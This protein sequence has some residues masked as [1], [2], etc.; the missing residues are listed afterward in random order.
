MSKY[1]YEKKSVYQTEYTPDLG[2]KFAEKY[3]KFLKNGTTERRCVD[4]L[5]ALAEQNGFTA[6]EKGKQYKAGD[7]VYLI[8]RGKAVAFV[9][10]GRQPVEAGVHIA[11]AH[12]D[13]PRLDLKP[14]PVAEQEELVLLKTHYY[15][16]IKKYQ[17]TAIPLSLEG[18]IIKKDGTAVDVHDDALTFCISDLLPHLASAQCEKTLDKAIEGEDLRVLAGSIP[19]LEEQSDKVKSAILDLIHEK[20][21]IEEVDLQCA[22]LTMVPK[23][24]PAEVG[25]DKSLI[26]AYGQDDRICAF[27]AFEGL[28]DVEIPDK[29][30]IV[31][32]ADKEEIGSDGVSGMQSR[33][34]ERM[35][36]LISGGGDILEICANSKCLSA[37][38][39]AA[40]D[41]LYPSVSE[42]QNTCLL[43]YGPCI[44]KYTGARGKSGTSDASAEVMRFFS[45][46]MRKDNVLF[47]TGE[48]GKVDAGGGG[49]V[50]MYMANRDIDTVDIG[51]GLLSMHAPFEISSKAD[52]YETYR[53][54][55]AF[56]K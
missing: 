28:L 1:A 56:L 36:S 30:A 35:L 48:L 21:G 14:N 19:D 18:V 15:G 27:T 13:S 53:A 55:R 32:L 38:V 37:D 42:K 43:G 51:V 29:T 9:T 45:E 23:L 5:V 22:E 25:F 24:E 44:T 6:F 12:I 10:F 3:L 17:W 54:M 20:Y 47:Q 39:N 11:A 40:L 41:P 2:N 16:G 33:F 50:A 8:N 34:F 46:I 4:Y 52:V 49:T 7:R 26:G 31:F